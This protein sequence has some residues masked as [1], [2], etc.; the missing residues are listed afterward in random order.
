MMLPMTEEW[1]EAVLERN[2]HYTK[3]GKVADYIPELSGADPDSLGA[4]IALPDGRVIS[5]GDCHLDFTLQSMSK[6]ISLLVALMDH[7]RQKVFS[8]VGMEPSVDPFNSIVKLETIDNKKPLNP[9][10][11]AGAIMVASLIKGDTAQDRVERVLDFLKHI[12]GNPK[13]HVNQKVFESERETGDRNRALAYFM[14]STGTMEG[15]VQRTLETY[16]QLCSIEVHCTDLARISL[17]L[18]SWGRLPGKSEQVVSPELVHIV[19]T[20]MITSGMYNQSGEFFLRVGLPAKSGVSGGIMAAV[21]HRM[22]IGVIGPAIDKI[23]N[24][25]AGVKILEELSNTLDLHLISP[26][27][28]SMKMPD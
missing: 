13:L 18:S 7:G 1:L 22:G 27:E 14:K 6:V 9:M 24:S 23:G 15:S 16:F 5:V 10:I 11:N 25:T 2:R 8:A 20:I 4:T 26:Q 3:D 12:T 19:L 21:P 28:T 17:F